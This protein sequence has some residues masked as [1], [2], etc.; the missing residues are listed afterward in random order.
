MKNVKIFLIVITILLVSA[1]PAY[2]HK[3]VIEPLEDGVIKVQY[4]DGSFSERTEVK[5]YN[6]KDE[7]IEEGKLDEEGKFTY[8]KSKEVSYIIAED[9]LGHKAEW[10]IG[11]ES[12][13]D[14]G[15]SKWVKI[16]AVVLVLVAIGGISY[17]KKK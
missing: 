12:K 14:S 1:V 8:D 2:A 10:K 3:M 15:G 6:S 9:G 13:K 7:V 11:E 17:K 5:V 16:G 4:D